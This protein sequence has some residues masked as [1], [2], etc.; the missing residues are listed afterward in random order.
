MNTKIQYL[1]PLIVLTFSTIISSC[2]SGDISDNTISEQQ[3]NSSVSPQSENSATNQTSPAQTPISTSSQNT[4]GQTTKVTLYT[5]DDQCQ[6]L[7]PKQT[8]VSA[9]EPMKAAIGK[10]LETQSNGDLSFAG[11]R[12]S[13]N[14]G[15][16]TIDLR[17][18]PESKRPIGGLSTCEQIALFGSL[19]KTLTSNASWN[20][21][22]VRFTE[23]GEELV[24]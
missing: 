11:Y 9:D 5:I 1:L 14:N 6:D 2:S 10:I 12:A 7:I 16:A 18:A 20:V 4:S 17:T 22:E 13:V 21:K 3:Q 24:F 15:V 23:Q 19:R 8:D